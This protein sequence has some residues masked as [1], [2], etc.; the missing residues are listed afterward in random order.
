MTTKQTGTADILELTSKQKTEKE[1]I[2]FLQEN[3]TPTLSDIIKLAFHP[4]VHFLMPVGVPPYTANSTPDL[5]YVL[6]REAKKLYL[7]VDGGG[8]HLTQMK[9]EM[10]F[11][12]ILER[13][14]P[15]DAELLIAM[16]DKTLPYGITYEFILKCFPGFLPEKE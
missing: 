9:R 1:K 5:E 10:M 6:P 16:K 7:F 12:E 4:G 3:M 2:R 11:I 8:N 15:K 14:T 13:V